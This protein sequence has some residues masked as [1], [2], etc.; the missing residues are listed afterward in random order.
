MA[1]PIDINELFLKVY[2]YVPPSFTAETLPQRKETSDKG[3]PYYAKDELGREYYMPVSL[4][5]F[6]LPLPLISIDMRKVIV[7]TPMVN[8]EGTVKELITTSDYRI[9]IR[10]ICCGENGQYPEEQVQLLADLFK[11]NRALDIENVLT[12]L[13][14]IEQ[15][16]ITDMTI[17]EVKGF[18]GVVGYQLDLLSDA[19]FEL[20]VS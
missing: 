13:F 8:R 20:I 19:P 10:G 12:A 11:Q 6:D 16:V 1:Q 14:D 4:G 9:R 18:K 3:A 5:V 7:D 17:N 15:A 2:G